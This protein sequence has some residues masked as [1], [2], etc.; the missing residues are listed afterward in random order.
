MVP[1]LALKC[2]NKPE[3]QYISKFIH[4]WLPLQDHYHVTSAAANNLCPSCHISMETVDHFSP[5]CTMIARPNGMTYTI[6]S[7]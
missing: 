1:H 7:I 2:L 6:D 5:A 4:K 3:Q